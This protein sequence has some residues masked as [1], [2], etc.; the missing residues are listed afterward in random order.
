VGPAELACAGALLVLGGAPLLGR[1]ARLGVA[2][3]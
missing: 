2:R 3:A 1:A